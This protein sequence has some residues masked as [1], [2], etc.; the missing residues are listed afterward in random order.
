VQPRSSL[1]VGLVVSRVDYILPRICQHIARL[2]VVLM[3]KRCG[4]G[5]WA[6]TD[7]LMVDFICVESGHMSE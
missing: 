6:C 5:R 7:S 1:A 3:L 2:V 4:G